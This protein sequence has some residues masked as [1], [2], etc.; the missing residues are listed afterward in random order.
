MTERSCFSYKALRKEAIE[1]LGGKCIKCA[2]QDARA[3]QIDHING[4]GAVELLN[5]DPL[6]YL[7][8][9]LLDNTCKY[10]LLCANC[11]WIKRAELSEATRGRCKEIIRTSPLINRASYRWITNGK[12]SKKIT[13][14]EIPENGWVF[15]RAPLREYDLS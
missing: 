14:A 3:L 7:E 1:K 2:F 10:Q 6:A 8:A 5:T 9:V 13:L 15:G 4:G 11:N 12:Q